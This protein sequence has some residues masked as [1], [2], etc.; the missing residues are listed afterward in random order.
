MWRR[1]SLLA[2]GLV[3]TACAAASSPSR[4]VRSAGRD[5]I[6]AAEIVA[7]RVTDVYQAVAHLRPEFLQRRAATIPAPTTSYRAPQITVYLDDMEFG[8]V[9]SMRHIPL[10]RVRLIRYV[11]PTEASLR[12]GGQHRGGVIHVVTLK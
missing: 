9:E 11:P 7:A 12:W 2:L 5:V 4:P 6:T 8:S 1:I 10:Q 3:S